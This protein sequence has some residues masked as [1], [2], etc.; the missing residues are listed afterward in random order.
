MNED[1]AAGTGQEPVLRLTG[2]KKSF[3]ERTILNGIDLDIHQGRVTVIMGGSGHGKS[4]LLKHLIGVLQ[5]DEGRIFYRGEDICRFDE[6]QWQDYKLKIGMVFQS[7]ALLNSMTVGDNVAL[8]L[9]EHSQLH[10]SIIEKVV[11]IKLE[12]VGLRGFEDL[13]PE[14]LSGGMRKRVGLARAI[15]MDPEIVFYDEPTS[16]LDPI[17]ASVIDQLVKDLTRKLGITS[18]VITHD[19]KSAFDIGDHMAML[20]E[21]RIIAEGTSEEIRV[22]DDPRVQQFI[23]G[24]PDGPIPMS[25]SKGSYLSD[26][27]GMD[28]P[29]VI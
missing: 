24:H 22:K 9:V 1:S 4:T 23:H 19:M 27:F 2:L 15:V 14:E 17:T 7:A 25:R 5:P 26:L 20:Y 16:G 29:R 18:V 28:E 10:S 11:K 12:M 21:G 3:G 8:P 6:Q 13:R